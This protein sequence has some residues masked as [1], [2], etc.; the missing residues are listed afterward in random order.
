VGPPVGVTE[1]VGPVQL[2]NRTP[3][4]PC[5]SL[6][7]SVK[8]VWGPPRDHPWAK[9]L[10]AAAISASAGGDFAALAFADQ[11]LFRTEPILFR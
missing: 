9:C 2:R 6:G 4:A 7:A 11:F 8:C 5:V 10:P 1:R 3:P